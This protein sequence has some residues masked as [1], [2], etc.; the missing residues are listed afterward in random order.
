[1]AETA[2]SG[3]SDAAHEELQVIVNDV[4][5]EQTHF[6]L[7]STAKLRELK[8]LVEKELNIHPRL[9]TFLLN[10]LPIDGDDALGLADCA[11]TY[12]CDWSSDDPLSLMIICVLPY[13]GDMMKA[14]AAGDREACRIIMT[15]R[16]KGRIFKTIPVHIKAILPWGKGSERGW[17]CMEEALE[18]FGWSAEMVSKALQEIYEK[19]GLT[20]SEV[21]FKDVRLYLHINYGSVPHLTDKDAFSTWQH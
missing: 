13:D 14:M 19:K 15:E 21:S 6:E 18:G 12:G 8:E 17:E 2:G 9:Q 5:G 11:S 1:M 10:G 7:P 20:R 4:S 3:V 16:D